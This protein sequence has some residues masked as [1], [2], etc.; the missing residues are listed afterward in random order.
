M[1]GGFDRMHVMLGG[2]S[3]AVE[4]TG[5]VMKITVDGKVRIDEGR[6]RTRKWP[7]AGPTTPRE[8]A[9]DS[10]RQKDAPP[11][12]HRLPWYAPTLGLSKWPVTAD[13]LRDAYRKLALEHHPDRG[14]RT[15][16]FLSL[17]RAH[18]AAKAALGVS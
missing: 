11:K 8:K 10:E 6:K 18:D 17:Q 4:I 9:A 5:G 3:I 16:N 13:E 12:G 1:S 15:T 7:G 14:G 2:R